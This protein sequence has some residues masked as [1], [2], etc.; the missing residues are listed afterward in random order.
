MALKINIKGTT[1]PIHFGYGAFRFLGNLWKLDG[2]GAVMQK[3]AKLENIAPTGLTFEQEDIVADVV[4]AGIH[5]ADKEGVI[6]LPEREDI[7]HSILFDAETLQ[8]I[9][10]EL[11]NAFPKMGNQKPAQKAG[12]PKP[13]KK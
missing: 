10:A 3:L 11:V 4:W 7:Q 13:K 5:C 9:F 12:K 2:T 1:Y 6:E 8:A